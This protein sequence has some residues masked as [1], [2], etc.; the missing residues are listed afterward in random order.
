MVKTTNLKKLENRLIRQKHEAIHGPIVKGDALT[1]LKL[2]NEALIFEIVS[3]FATGK[4]LP[5]DDIN[6]HVAWFSHSSINF[7]KPTR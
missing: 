6:S 3:S 4:E 2:E 1:K 7:R 5:V